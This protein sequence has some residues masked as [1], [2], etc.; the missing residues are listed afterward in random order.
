MHMNHRHYLLAGL[1]I[2]ASPFLLTSNAVSRDQV[3]FALAQ[4]TPAKKD[5]NAEQKKEMLKNLF[6]SNVALRAQL[7]SLS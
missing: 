1:M 6:E 4:A 2:V 5:Q 3:P 7:T